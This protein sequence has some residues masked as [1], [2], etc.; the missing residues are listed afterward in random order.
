MDLLGTKAKIF[1]VAE[2][3]LREIYREVLSVNFETF[4]YQ[5]LTRAL[6]ARNQVWIFWGPHQWL[7]ASA[8]ENDVANEGLAG[9]GIGKTT[10][11]LLT[12][13]ISSHSSLFL[14]KSWAI[15]FH[16]WIHFFVLFLLLWSLIIN[17]ELNQDYTNLD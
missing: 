14:P 17:L 6:H 5:H 1:T 10:S 11:F 8:R 2:V 15:N 3:L 16:F 4:L 12:R 13:W 9:F 7:E